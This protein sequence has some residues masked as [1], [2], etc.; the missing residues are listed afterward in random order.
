MKKSY[1]FITALLMLSA[2]GNSQ[3][4]Q[5]QTDTAD[6]TMVESTASE[7]QPSTPDYHFDYQLVKGDD[8]DYQSIIVKGYEDQNCTF[9][10]SHDLV[11]SVSEESAADTQWIIDTEDINFDGQPDLQIFLWHTAVGQV[12]RSYAA[13]TITPQHQIEEV[14]QW[15]DLCNPEIHPD[16]RT[17]TANYRSDINE[18]TYDTYQWTPDNTLELIDTRTEPLF[19]EE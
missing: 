6:T 19:E 12:I 11:A 8:G 14:K 16:T 9:E 3:Q 18:R 15:A 13:Y 4:K 7:T 17:I 10:C 2:C 1:L 5:E